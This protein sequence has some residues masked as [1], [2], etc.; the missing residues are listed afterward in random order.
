MTLRDLEAFLWD[1]QHAAELIGG[2]VEGKTLQDYLT[3]ELL[4]SGVERQLGIIGEAANQ[5]LRHF[6]SIEEKISDLPKIIAFRNR[7][8]H[9]Y[10][11][12]S[13]EVVWAIATDDVPKLLGEVKA[14]LPDLP[15]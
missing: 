10:A 15:E 7:L 14:T 1:I 11:E 9:G 5:A 13:D 4:R 12:I 6:P 8:I 3:D 2:F